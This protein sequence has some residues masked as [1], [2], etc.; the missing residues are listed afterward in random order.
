MINELED[1]FNRLKVSD[2]ALFNFYKNCIGNNTITINVAKVDNHYVFSLNRAPEQNNDKVIASMANTINSYHGTCAEPNLQAKIGK[3]LV[4][5]YIYDISIFIRKNSIIVKEHPPC[6][7]CN[8][9]VS[10]WG[11]KYPKTTIKEH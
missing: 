5:K 3:K 7:A 11:W 8:R 10:L 6:S 9:N 4:G 2:H 1:Y